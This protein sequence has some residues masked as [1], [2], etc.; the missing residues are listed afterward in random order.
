MF[1]KN[2]SQILYQQKFINYKHKK[3]GKIWFFLLRGS[4][5]IENAWISPHNQFT[6]F[7]NFI[8]NVHKEIW[9]NFFGN[10]ITLN[11]LTIE[12]ENQ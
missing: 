4:F 8:T 2:N 12:Q 5:A 10:P 6:S 1:G 11:P 9:Q 3:F 7:N